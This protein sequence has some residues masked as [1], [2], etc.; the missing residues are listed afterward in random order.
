MGRKKTIKAEKA[1]APIMDLQ[2]KFNEPTAIAKPAIK[3]PFANFVKKHGV[4][5]TEAAAL[6]AILPVDPDGLISEENFVEGRAK[7]RRE[8]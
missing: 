3:R 7:W 4:A 5:D 1:V 8:G 6:K 2:P